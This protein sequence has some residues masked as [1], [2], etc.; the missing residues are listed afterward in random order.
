MSR[1]NNTAKR[2]A[3]VETKHNYLCTVKPVVASRYIGTVSKG[4]DHKIRAIATRPS[5]SSRPL[6]K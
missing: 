1:K 6:I 5:K 4:Y 2:H 3:A